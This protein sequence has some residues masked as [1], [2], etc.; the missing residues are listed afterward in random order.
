MKYF[1]TKS[2]AT[3]QELFRA[4][5][6]TGEPPSKTTAWK[7]I[8]RYANNG[9]S[10]NLSAMQSKRKHKCRS[11]EN[12]NAIERPLKT[13]FRFNNRMLYFSRSNIFALYLSQQTTL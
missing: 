8:K 3:V 7:N 4:Q 10:L 11:D 1:E 2:H 13:W 9:T 6:I 5:F 12:L